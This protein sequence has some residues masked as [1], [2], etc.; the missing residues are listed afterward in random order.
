MPAPDAVYLDNAATTR[1]MP[2]VVEAMAQVQLEHFGNPSS[3]HRFGD[4]PRRLLQDAR[5]FLR[6]TL[7]AANLV[8]TSGGTEADLLGVAGAVQRRS[9]GRVLCAASDHPAIL[10]QANLLARTRHRLVP[11]PVTEDGDLDPEVFFDHLGR[12]VRAIAILHGH[13]ELGTLSALEEL[14]SL[15]RRVC[16]NAHIHVDLV[17]SYGKIPFDLDNAGVDSVAVSGHKLHGPRGVGFL[18]CSSTAEI[19]PLQLGGGQEAGLRG[20]TENVAGAVGLAT[21]AEAAFTHL[22]ATSDH[23]E[24][25][26]TRLLGH[27]AD[28][29]PEVERLGHPDS[30]LPHILSVR[31]P[32]VVAATLLERA[33]ADGIAFSTGAA[34][35]SGDEQQNPV[36]ASIGLNRKQAREVLRFSFSRFNTTDEV[37]R[38]AARV[39]EHA[40]EL[41]RQA[42]APRAR[43]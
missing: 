29:F 21:A 33:N 28:A 6:G 31:L 38:A 7:S 14:V 27:L 11:L 41:L 26:A 19:A 3:A 22:S 18:A 30:R 4:Q 36:L 15:A 13:N 34:C 40:R 9:P 8:F 1:P 12:D 24:A 35:H 23:T 20:G 32:G 10:Q 39:V 43:R 25:L 37:D 42:P 17:Q 16:P 5:E 2:E